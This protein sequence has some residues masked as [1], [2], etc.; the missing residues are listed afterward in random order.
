M[1]KQIHIKSGITGKWERYIGDVEDTEKAL[2]IN[3]RIYLGDLKDE[4][5]Q[6]C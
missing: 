4:G 1:E 2:K 3:L 6:E 5:K